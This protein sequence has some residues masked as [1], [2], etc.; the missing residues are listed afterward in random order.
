MGQADA[1]NR[2]R[3]VIQSRLNSSRLPGKALMTIGGMP[4]IELVARRASRTGYEVVVATSVEPYDDRIADHLERVGIPVLRGDLD[5]VLGRFVAATADLAADDLVVRLTGDNPIMDADVIAELMSAMQGSGHA[6]GRVDIDAV[7]EGLGCEVFAAGDLRRAGAAATASY[8]R[9]HVTPWLRRTLGELLFAPAGNPGQPHAYRATVDCLD[10]YDRVSRLF[11]G[12]DDPVHVPW[13]TLM[14]R[15]VTTVDAGPR[16]SEID[17]PGPRLTSVIIGTAGL[18]DADASVVR[19]TFTDA[20]ARGV[21]HVVA[22]PG[23]A[24]VV[25]AGTL[26]ALRQRIGA[27]VTLPRIE[28]PIDGPAH[29]AWQVR[30]GVERAM[31]DIGG[32]RLAGVL[33]ASAEDAFAGD[34]AAWTTLRDYVDQGLVDEI[35]VV[36]TEPEQA[37]MLDSLDGLGLVVVDLADERMVAPQ[38]SD[39]LAALA[40]DV[41]ILAFAAANPE[42]QR[43]VLAVPWVDAVVGSPTCSDDLDE[44]LGTAASPLVFGA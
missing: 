10:D 27:I 29:L 38:A 18:V 25:A 26:P 8:D 23:E 31:A 5:D 39:H 21:S 42:A 7:P 4:L 43:A 37:G 11:D 36:L 19:Q 14:A 1:Q 22:D 40:S 35:G 33:F 2:T 44:L 6:Y 41:T 12:I 28:T 3:V 34:G 17:R 15:L 20:V 16:A 32:R 30:A 24:S 9:E 13:S